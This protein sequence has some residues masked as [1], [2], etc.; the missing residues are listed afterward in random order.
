MTATATQE[1]RIALAF[2]HA[3][4]WAS[5]WVF[6]LGGRVSRA[7]I[8][9]SVAAGPLGDDGQELRLAVVVDGCDVLVVQLG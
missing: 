5:G 9:L 4:S 8:W 7:A 2:H 6:R 1:V 3:R